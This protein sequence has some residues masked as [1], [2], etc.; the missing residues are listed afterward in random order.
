MRG[1]ACLAQGG[2]RRSA[3]MGASATVAAEHERENAQPNHPCSC[4]S[5]CFHDRQPCSPTI[6]PVGE[7]GA[8]TCRQPESKP[9]WD[10]LDVLMRVAMPGSWQKSQ[11]L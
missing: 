4:V 11:P 1:L 6:Q 2:L 5:L 9:G 8:R 10:I 7:F 3:A